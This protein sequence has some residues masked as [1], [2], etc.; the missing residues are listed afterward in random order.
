MESC[1]KYTQSC[2]Y[3]ISF[4]LLAPD[5]ECVTG[6]KPVF[7]VLSRAQALEL[8]VHHNAQPEEQTE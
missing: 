5:G 1:S 7:E 6:S 8:T 2:V 4:S 3:L